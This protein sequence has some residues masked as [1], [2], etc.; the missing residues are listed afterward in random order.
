M[1]PS[2]TRSLIFDA[3]CV[4]AVLFPVVLAAYLVDLSHR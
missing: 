4:I 3:M 2:S 1:L